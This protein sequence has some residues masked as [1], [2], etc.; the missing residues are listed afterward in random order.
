MIPEYL[1]NRPFLPLVT[2]R[3]ILRAYEDKD[4]EALVQLLKDKRIAD[5][6]TRIPYPYTLDDA[7]TWIKKTRE[8]LK[9][10]QSVQL[11]I[12]RQ[13][14]QTLI[15]GIGLE[16]ELGYWLGVAH[17]GQGLMTEAVKA[18]LHFAFVTLKVNK[19]IGSAKEVNTAS[20]QIF[21]R[22]GFRE[23]GTKQNSSVTYALESSDFFTAFNAIKRPLVW[24]V[25]AALVNERKLLLASRPPGKKLAGIW[26]L[27]G[28]KLEANETPEQALVRE[29]KE[30]LHIDVCAEELEPLTFASYAYDTFHLIMP[31]YLCRKWQGKPQGIE[32]Q[33]L[34]WV[35]YSDLVNYP[36]PPP[37][38]MLTHRLADVLMREGVW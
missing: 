24:V 13:Q 26:E 14:D 20:K 4:A 8:G 7:N 21:K 34:A 33:K 18:L 9:T 17:W 37:D 12:I 3:L 38:I 29:L 27:P 32:G 23:T 1:Q 35:T 10:G 19:I 15:G 25:A 22:M 28:G 16:E 5:M 30:E 11:A 36:F 2:D 6:T 31:L